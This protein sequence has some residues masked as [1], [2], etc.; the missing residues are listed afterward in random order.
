VASKHKDKA[1][2]LLAKEVYQF[3]E[4]LEVL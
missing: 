2:Q 3:A 4:V 1:N